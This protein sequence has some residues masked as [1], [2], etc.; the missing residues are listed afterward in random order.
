MKKF[1]TLL[2]AL[3][4]SVSTFAQVEKGTFTL[5]PMVGIDV[6][7]LSGD[8]GSVSKVKNG[9]YTY[10]SKVGFVGG[11]EGAYQFSDRFGLSV[12]VLYAMGGSKIDFTYDGKSVDD[13][14]GMSN[15]SKISVSSLNVPVLVNFY[16]WKGLAI[17]A[18]I[19]PQFLLS[20]KMKAKLDFDGESLYDIDRDVKDDCNSVS[21]AVPVGA[22]YDFPFG[23]TVDARYNIGVTN[24]IKSDAGSALV[25]MVGKHNMFQLTVGYKFHL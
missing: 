18:G 6:T 19:Q 11:V 23:L 21:L 9:T 3:V 14:D 17:K 5:Q 10:K 16:V 15:D 8:G 13:I 12:G 25:D 7:S 24:V 4:A 20:A 2:V 1:A 22:S